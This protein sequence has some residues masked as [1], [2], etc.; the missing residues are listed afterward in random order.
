MASVDDLTKLIIDEMKSYTEEIDKGMQKEIDRTAKEVKKDLESNPN[1]PE[2][3][4]K[5]R[6]SFYIKKEAQGMGYKRVRVANRKYQL[7]H[8]LEKGHAIKDGTGRVLGEAKAFEHWES[9][10]RIADTLPKRMEEV[11]KRGT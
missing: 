8:L 10:Q 4:K 3:T 9:A 6:K 11:I 2:R 7:T 5:Y 1:V